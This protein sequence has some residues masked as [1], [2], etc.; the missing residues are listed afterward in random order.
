[1]LLGR[2]ENRY[3]DLQY[4]HDSVEGSVYEPLILPILLYGAERLCFT[5]RFLQ[6][7][8]SFHNRCVR[9][10]CRVNKMQTNSLRTSSET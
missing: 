5:E 6:K 4:V 7:L 3:L 2:F 10:M 1:M 9:A 8:G